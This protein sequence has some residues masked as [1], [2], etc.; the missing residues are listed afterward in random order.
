MSTVGSAYVVIRAISPSLKKDIAKAAESA[1][2]AAA[3]A[4]DK[5]A[6]DIDTN[7]GKATT[8]AAQHAGKAAAPAA[9]S[10]GM[11]IGEAMADALPGGYTKKAGAALKRGLAR[12]VKAAG[13]DKEGNNLGNRMTRGFS[14]AIKDFKIPLPVMLG[15]LGVPAIGG[16]LQIIGAY[17]AGAISLVGAMGPAFAS[18]GGVGVASFLA[19]GGAVGAVMLALKTASP[20]LNRFKIAAGAVGKEFQTIGLSVQ[21]VLL[22]SLAAAMATSTKAIPTLTTGMTGLGRAVGGVAE[23]LARVVTSSTFLTNIGTVFRE[24]GPQVTNYG[25]ALGSV[26][27]IFGAIAA[28]SAPIATRFSAFIANFAAAAEKATLAGQA[29]GRLANFMERGAAVAAQLGQI[30]GDVGRGLFNVFSTA[31]A[32]GQTLLDSIS[33]LAARFAAWSG[34]MQGQNTLR[35]FFDNAIPVLHEVNG[36]IGDVL[37]MIAQPMASG[38][39]SGVIGF[40]QS[41]RT[42]LLPAL[43][44]ISRAITG[45]GVGK[46][47]TDLASAVAD[48]ITSM[49]NSGALG[50][51]TS[52]L[53]TM[54]NAI[55]QLLA[56]PVVGQLLG[57]GLAFGGMAKAV[58]LVLKPIGGLGTILNP[59]G[60][61]LFGTADKAGLLSR[62]GSKLAPVLKTVGTAILGIGR[63]FLTAIGPVGWVILGISALVAGLIYA[64]KHSEAFRNIVQAVWAAIQTAIGA[65]VGWITGTV[66]PAIV[67]AWNWIRDG[68]VSLWQTIS[69]AFSSVVAV[70]GGFIGTVV[71]AVVGFVATIAGYALTLLNWI[72][73]PFRIGI[74]IVIGIVNV[75]WGFIQPVF[76]AIGGFIEGVAVRVQNAISTAFNAVRNVVVTVVTAVWGFLVSVWNAIFGFI[77]GVVNRIWSAISAAF[78]AVRN[79]VMSVFN[80]VR[81]FV[82]SVWNAIYSFISG[83]VNRIRSAISNAFNAFIG[84]VSG[85]VNRLRSIISTGFTNMVNAIAG[86][87]GRARTAAGSIISGIT[88]AIRNGISG[89]GRIGG[90]LVQGLI[91]GITGMGGRLWGAITR[92]ID[93]HVPG[94]IKKLLGIASPSKLMAQIGRQ[95]A[96]G[97]QVGFVSSGAMISKAAGSMAKAAMSG[98]DRNMGSLT[99]P[100]SAATTVSGRPTRGVPTPAGGILVQ[101]NVGVDDL[102]KMS[103]VGD[104]VTMLQGGG[105][106][107]EQRK[108]LRSGTVTV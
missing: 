78:N 56:L 106:R 22:P 87:L 60:K 91:N 98:F 34:S 65:V 83:A 51:F 23:N 90:D 35:N 79:V 68:V 33:K 45:A 10:A 67:G 81:G 84:I 19:V 11:Q 49:A 29:S 62:I 80:A 43:Q 64:Y 3:P 58:D 30:V 14:K 46:S 2:K 53:T 63:A 74:A 26:L 94:P 72:T 70:V 77:S 39:T 100:V 7:V 99:V 13:P 89:I 36:L 28:V 40:V 107:V 73:Y 6:K 32:S 50:A 103:V 69:S 75:L 95:T 57:W 25:K 44:Q 21:R 20:M 61:L 97:L 76:A 12:A 93:E 4:M 86:F 15:F 105:A 47:M 59:L 85:P 102:A 37:R 88:D 96:Q 1:A 52:T 92:F 71:S 8:R 16:A 38:N 82:S 27:Q 66:V 9:K 31:S 54:I 101:M 18:I 108:T 24:G 104:F 5:V 55:A 17:V 42:D 41:L 48:L